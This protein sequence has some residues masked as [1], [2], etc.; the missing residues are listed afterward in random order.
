MVA[1]LRSMEESVY[2]KD[3]SRFKSMIKIEKKIQDR[4]PGYVLR[5]RFVTN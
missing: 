2:C 1:N 4:L 5:K 3:I